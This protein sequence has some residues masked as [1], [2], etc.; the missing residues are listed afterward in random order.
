M[1]SK[2]KVIDLFCGCGGLTQGLVD[3]GLDVICGID[4]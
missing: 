1:K 4:I 2:F 3:S